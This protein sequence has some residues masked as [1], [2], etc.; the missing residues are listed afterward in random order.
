MQFWAELAVPN[1]PQPILRNTYAKD[2]Q[3]GGYL[4]VLRTPLLNKNCTVLEDDHFMGN[5]IES[6][7]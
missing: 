6:S 7:L 3:M 5:F 2:K 1:T 4:R